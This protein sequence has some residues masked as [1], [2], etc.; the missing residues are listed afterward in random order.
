MGR[1]WI[2]AI[3]C[4]Y[5]EYNSRLKE[6]FINGLNN[7]NIKAKIFKELT[8][9]KDASKLSSMQVFMWAKRVEVQRVQ[10]VVLDN[11]RDMKQFYSDEE[12]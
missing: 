11:I 12:R 4:K 6:Q 5:Q 10:K 7:E 9:L 1:L 2:N 3:V 8:A